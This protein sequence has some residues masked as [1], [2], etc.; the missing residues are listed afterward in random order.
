MRQL[1]HQYQLPVI[2]VHQPMWSGS[3]VWWDLGWVAAAA[4]L[5]ARTGV[6]HPLIRTPLDHPRMQSYLS[7]FSKAQAQHNVHLCLENMPKHMTAGWFWQVV[8]PIEPS[9]ARLPDLFAAATRYQ[10]GLT[11][12]TSHTMVQQPHHDPD[13]LAAF[14]H[15]HHIHL[16]SFVPDKEHLRL[17]QGNLDHQGFLQ[18]L[19]AQQ[20][21]GTMTIELQD[22]ALITLTAYPKE[23]VRQSYMEIQKIYQAEVI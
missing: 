11:Y 19:R 1:S 21:A 14:P 18:W 15:I 10:M 17:G 7:A 9:H 3:G 4:A 5:G 6:L 16:S 22:P 23:P 8:A 13:F 20:Y 12:D 2:A